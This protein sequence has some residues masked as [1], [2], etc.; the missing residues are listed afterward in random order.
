MLLERWGKSGAKPSFANLNSCSWRHTTL[1][2]WLF[3]DPQPNICFQD[4]SF[5][6]FLTNLGISC[7]VKKVKLNPFHVHVPFYASIHF[8]R[9]CTCCHRQYEILEFSQIMFLRKMSR[10]YV[11]L[12]VFNNVSI[13]IKNAY[14]GEMKP[15]LFFYQYR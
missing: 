1:L 10:G 3:H 9:P 6:C 7:I 11:L 5:Q 12:G 8:F 14:P 4:F 2:M 15:L 13:E